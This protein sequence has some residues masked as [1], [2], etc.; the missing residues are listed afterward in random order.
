M[1][2]DSY[3]RSET[4]TQLETGAVISAAI[5]ALDLSQFQNEAGVLAL[6]A[7]ELVPYTGTKRKSRP[8]WRASSPNTPRAAP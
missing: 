5:D 6:I 2:S 1:E 8:T 7:G 3:A 4:Y